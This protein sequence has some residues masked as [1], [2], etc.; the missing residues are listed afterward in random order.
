MLVCIHM[1]S[2]TADN[3]LE[4]QIT[5]KFNKNNTWNKVW[6]ES[7]IGKR[8]L[9]LWQRGAKIL[10]FLQQEETKKR[11]AHP[12]SSFLH[13]PLFL[14]VSPMHIKSSEDLFLASCTNVSRR[15]NVQHEPESSSHCS[16]KCLTLISTQQVPGCSQACG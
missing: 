15:K 5:P 8:P 3:G 9:L 2:S 11:E 12:P 13:Y 4:K 6:S 16:K 10:Y 14:C 7:R 1:S